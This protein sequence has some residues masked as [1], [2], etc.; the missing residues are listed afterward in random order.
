MIEKSR[1][2]ALHSVRYGENSLIAYLYSQQ[3]GRITL[4]VNSAYG[5]G[6][7]GKKAIYFQPLNILNIVFY[8]GKNQGMGRLK[9][10]M[11]NDVHNT[12]H[13]NH[14]KSAIALFIGEIIYRTVREEESNLPLYQFLELSIR[15]LDV[16]ESKTPN[17]HLIFLAQLS[18]YLGFFPS[19]EYSEST[20]YFDYKNGLFV[21]NKPVHPMY[22]SMEHSKILSTALINNYNNADNLNLN[23]N[24]R[25]EF[26]SQMIK[27][28]AFH[29]DSVQNVRSLEI[30]HQVF[31]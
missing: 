27:Y 16:L 10:I 8:P 6:K 23:R 9:E 12:I 31:E 21:S 24:M 11:L 4:M 2:I 17:F 3:H 15:T 29:T 25:N 7:A 26:L 28:Y 22:F 19:G 1:A 13:N 20:P 30:L 5:K 18:K 14:T